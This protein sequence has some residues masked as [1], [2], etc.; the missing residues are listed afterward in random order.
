MLFYTWAIPALSAASL[1]LDSAFAFG[2]R[3]GK[4]T[5]RSMRKQ[6]NAKKELER[7]QEAER[8]AFE[9]REANYTQQYRFYSHDTSRM[10]HFHQLE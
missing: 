7:R 4:F 8:R 2:G 6:E 10:S 9:A 5:E 3:A 1:L